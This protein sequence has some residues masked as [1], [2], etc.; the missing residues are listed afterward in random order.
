MKKFK[1]NIIESEAGWGSKIEDVEEF[2]TQEEADDFIVKFNKQNNKD[3]VPA[4][5][6]RA[7]PA[8][9]TSIHSNPF[10]R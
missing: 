9:Y 6:M 4:W 2:D 5:Y 10:R 1:V 3:K 8:N 7:E